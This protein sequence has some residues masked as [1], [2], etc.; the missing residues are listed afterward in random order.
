MLKYELDER[1]TVDYMRQLTKPFE[2]IE[3]TVLYTKEADVRKTLERISA[4]RDVSPIGDK[5]WISMVSEYVEG[6]PAAKT[7]GYK[8]REGVLRFFTDRQER[9]LKVLNALELDAEI[10]TLENADYE[11]VFEQL[12]R[13]VH[14]RLKR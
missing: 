11:S 9:A 7:H 13:T 1:A 2:S 4:E 14:A 6:Q 5:D 8:G 3:N 12:Q 10:F